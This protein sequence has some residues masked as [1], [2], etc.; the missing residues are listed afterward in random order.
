MIRK[1]HHAITALQGSTSKQEDRHHACRVCPESLATDRH[2]VMPQVRHWQGQQK[3]NATMC[4]ECKLGSHLTPKAAKCTLCGAGKFSNVKGI[5]C[6]DCMKGQYRGDDPEATSC[7]AC[8][9]GF[10]R[11]REDRH[12]A[13]RVCPE[14]LATR[15]V[16]SHATS[17]TLQGE[18][19]AKCHSMLRLQG[20][21]VISAKCT[22]WCWYQ[23]CQGHRLQG[24]HE[25]AI[26][27]G[28]DP[29]ATSCKAC[30]QGFYQNTG[31]Q[32]SCLPC[33]PE[34]LATRQVCSHAT[35]ATLA[36]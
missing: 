29:E 14:S 1:P 17:A 5:D 9:Q 25:G 10:I 12:L 7:K 30:G 15:Q 32:A 18:R 20:G 21:A 19:R 4:L 34:S 24:L 27:R 31:G 2:A 33:L 16:C 23:Q 3:P 22:L 6:K 8:G 28:D 11:T 13:C 26:S 35:S 36:R